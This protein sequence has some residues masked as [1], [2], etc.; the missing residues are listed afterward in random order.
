M[1]FEVVALFLRPICILK[2]KILQYNIHLFTDT[3][4]VICKIIVGERWERRQWREERPERV[5]A[6]CVQRR[7]TVAKAHTGHRNRAMTTH[8]SMCLN[9]PLRNVCKRRKIY[10][11]SNWNCS[12]GGCSR[13]NNTKFDKTLVTLDLYIEHKKAVTQKNCG[14]ALI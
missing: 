2:K 13:Y 11:E 10:Y 1:A 9:R 5:A 3:N 6:V 7:R 12:S 4:S 8:G 14:T